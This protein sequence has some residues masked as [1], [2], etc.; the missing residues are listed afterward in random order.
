MNT[1]FIR[2]TRKPFCGSSWTFLKKQSNSCHKGVH[3]CLFTGTII[4]PWYI[5]L[6]HI[7][8][9]YFVTHFPHFYASS[10]FYWIFRQALNL[11][12]LFSNLGLKLEYS[13]S[14]K[15]MVLSKAQYICL[16]NIVR[17]CKNE[18]AKLRRHPSRWVR[19]ELKKLGS[20]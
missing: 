18:H 8:G 6:S 14:G 5:L 16:L 15:T 1:G 7:F 12:A 19:F 4:V 11:D 2:L 13:M 9:F 20:N 17:H 3:H 10:H